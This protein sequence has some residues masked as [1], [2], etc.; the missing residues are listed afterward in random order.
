M[1]EV[2]C[3]V[4]PKTHPLKLPET[5]LSVSYARDLDAVRIIGLLSRGVRKVPQGES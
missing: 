5:P 2:S 1:G 3:R 4:I